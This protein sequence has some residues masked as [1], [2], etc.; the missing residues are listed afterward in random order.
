M[1]A[2]AGYG[3]TTTVADRL[4][5]LE[6]TS[7]WYRLEVG[8]NDPA[9]FAGYLAKSLEVAAPGSCKATLRKLQEKGYDD[10][11][12]FLTDLLAELPLDGEP[13]Y[14]VLDDYHLI[15]NEVIHNALRFLLRHQ[16]ACLTLVLITRTVPPIGV[17]QLR[18]QGRMTEI[19]SRDLADR[20]SVV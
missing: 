16:P 19:T 11:E 13:L 8:D 2:P 12:V 9:R 20:K 6:A 5:A 18:M 3:K 10:L 4:E 7:A 15:D 1:H 17:A 14:L